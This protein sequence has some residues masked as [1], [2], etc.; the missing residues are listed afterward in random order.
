MS[1]KINNAKAIYLEGIRDGNY[2]E[3][4]EKYT[5]ARYTQHSTGVKDGKEGF[6]EF[7][8]DF[9]QRC[10]VRDIQIVRTWEDGQ[11]VFVQ[12]YQNINNGEAQWVTTDFFDTDENDKMIEHWDVIQAYVDKTPSGHTSIDG[13]TEVTDLDKTEENKA[14]VRSLIQ[15]ALM[16]GGNTSKL[17]QYVSTEKY[18]QHNPEVEDGFEAFQ[19]LV[20]APNRPLNYQEIVLLVG[21]GNFVA[22]LCK[23]TW[24]E[25][26]KSQDFAQVDIFRIEN[27]KVVEH[28]DCAEPV[29]EHSVNGGKF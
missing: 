16:P 9:V 18:I 17:D 5:G 29:P 22:T 20:T 12:A 27:G 25:N 7:F 11:Y 13:P 26:G 19:R 4:V 14:L 28:W 10:P 2:R 6:I 1:Q 8:E 23:A 24:T 15:N 21:Q 3:A